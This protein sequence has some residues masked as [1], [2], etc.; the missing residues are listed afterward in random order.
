[1]SI[2]IGRSPKIEGTNYVTIDDDTIIV[3]YIYYYWYYNQ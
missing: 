1:M 3:Y 2:D